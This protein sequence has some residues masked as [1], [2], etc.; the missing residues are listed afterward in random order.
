MKK[1]FLSHITLLL[2]IFGCSSIDVT[3]DYD[4]NAD[5]NSYKS[6]Y[7][8]SGVLKDSK[9][10]AVPLVKKRVLEAAAAELQKKGFTLVD[11]SKAD[12][13]VFALA[14]TT[15]KMNVNTYGYGYGYGWGPYPSGR[16]ID[17]SYY[18]QGS[19]IL[20]FVDNKKD[21]LIWRGIGSAVVQDKG[22]PEEREQFIKEA[23]AKILEQYPPIK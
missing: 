13:T 5:F 20:D 8:F 1:S 14:T 19:L 2:I 17:V 22:T 11:S 23:V 3:S 18:T 6:F 7:V 10:E 4:L 16:N 15:E 12:F 21:E 9:L